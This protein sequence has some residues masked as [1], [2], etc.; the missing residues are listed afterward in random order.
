MTPAEAKKR[1]IAAFDLEWDTDIP[2]L[3]T[4]MAEARRAD[5]RLLRVTDDAHAA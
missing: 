1:V 4:L 3:E 5:A 2:A